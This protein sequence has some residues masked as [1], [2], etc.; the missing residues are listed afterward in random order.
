MKGNERYTNN[1][2]SAA[3]HSFGE[4]QMHSPFQFLYLRILNSA[5]STD[6][7]KMENIAN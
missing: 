2:R 5:K 6:A 7:M 1:V 3:C 4:R